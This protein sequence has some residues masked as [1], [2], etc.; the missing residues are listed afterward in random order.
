MKAWI[1]KYGR[2][3]GGLC[4]IATALAFWFD[5]KPLAAALAVCAVV[6]MAAAEKRIES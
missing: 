1:R 4:A 6:L 3:A 5:I 2:N